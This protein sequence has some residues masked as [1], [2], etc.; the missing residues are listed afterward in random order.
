MDDGPTA[1][2]KI[3][4]SRKTGKDEMALEK[5]WEQREILGQLPRCSHQVDKEKLELRAELIYPTPTKG[6]QAVPAVQ[7]G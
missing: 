6:C 3:I 1:H 4:S 2:R 5:A 7:R